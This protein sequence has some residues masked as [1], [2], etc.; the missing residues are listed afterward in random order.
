MKRPYKLICEERTGTEAFSFIVDNSCDSFVHIIDLVLNLVINSIQ[1][2]NVYILLKEAFMLSLKFSSIEENA[3]QNDISWLQKSYHN[4]Y[5][6]V[7]YKLYSYIL[8]YG[9]L[10]K[11]WFFPI[12][13]F[14]QRF[15]E[16]CGKRSKKLYQSCSN[17]K[18]LIT[19]NTSFKIREWLHNILICKRKIM[20]FLDF[21]QAA[22]SIYIRLIVTSASLL[23]Q[24]SFPQ[25]W[26]SVCT[27][28]ET[29]LCHPNLHMQRAKSALV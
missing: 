19:M 27:D 11:Y 3:F 12:P 10:W 18:S 16:K 2:E 9:V 13:L 26:I 22:I 5:F 17:L 28:I 21:V 29:W 7:S 20:T 8:F 4:F 1:F 6:K 23:L 14:W 25:M 24:K 15:P